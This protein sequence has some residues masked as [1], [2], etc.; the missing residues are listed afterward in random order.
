MDPPETVVAYDDDWPVH[1]EGIAERLRPVLPETTRI[2]HVGSTSVP[3]L[4]AKP[5]IDVDLVVRSGADVPLVIEALKPLGFEHRGD[6][7][8]PGREA[9][10]TLEGW[11]YHHLYVVVEGAP[12]H[13]DHLDVR[14]Y[15]RTHP[16]QAA[17]Y[18][19]EKRRL[20]HLLAT[21]QQAYVLGKGPIITELL[22][23]ARQP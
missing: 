15:L 10:N 6:G 13:R 18:A 11:P 7:G 8:I 14:D 9:F 1:F 2:V 5:I 23:L 19:E 16:A 3:G 21:D 17:L 12:P 4:C 20:E 22:R